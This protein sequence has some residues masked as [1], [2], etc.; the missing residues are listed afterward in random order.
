[1][2]FKKNAYA[3]TLFLWDNGTPHFHLLNRYIP[4]KEEAN[5]EL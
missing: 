5:D 4:Q 2:L 3:Y 1:M